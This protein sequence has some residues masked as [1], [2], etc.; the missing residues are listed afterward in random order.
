MNTNPAQ[1]EGFARSCDTI[2][3]A[4]IVGFGV[5]VFADHPPV[6]MTWWDA[7]RLVFAA[8]LFYTWGYNLRATP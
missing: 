2:A 8:V 4:C 3:T 7:V 5:G 6:S 1:R